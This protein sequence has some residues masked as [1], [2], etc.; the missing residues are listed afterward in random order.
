MPEGE[1]PRNPIRLGQHQARLPYTW[2][3]GGDSSSK[4][5]SF[6]GLRRTHGERLLKQ[7]RSA[8]QTAE[9]IVLPTLGD[10]Y[11]A[12]KG[13]ILVFAV[14]AGFARQLETFDSVQSGVELLNVKRYEVGDGDFMSEATVFVAHGSLK[15]FVKRIEEYVQKESHNTFVDPIQEIG[16]ATLENLWTVQ[17]PLPS[18]DKPV[19]WELWV[20]RGKTEQS[21]KKNVEAIRSECERHNFRIQRLELELP[22]HT[23]MLMEASAKKLAAAFGILN[24]LA[25][26]REPVKAVPA[27]LSPATTSGSPGVVPPSPPDEEAAVVCVLD[28]GVNRDHPLLAPVCPEQNCASWDKDW[29]GADID[30]HGTE[31]CG[32]AAFGDLR[33]VADGKPM[34]SATHWIES[35]KLLN[36]PGKR[37]HEPENYGAVTV[38]CMSKFEGDR[39]NRVF[40]MAITSEEALDFPHLAPDGLPHVLVC[41]YR[42]SNRVCS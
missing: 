27:A 39:S 17:K 5:K 26:V 9:A 34:P 19:W 33:S 36:D 6:P 11:L 29:T 42:Q 3:E 1:Q 10:D 7:L 28:T 37:E 38:E 30:G 32:V 31:M 13:F 18:H 8:E 4:L 20:R 35:V 14:D 22:E 21:K 16:L 41:R 25:E 40:S 2:N 23:V 24:C 12:E 15:Y